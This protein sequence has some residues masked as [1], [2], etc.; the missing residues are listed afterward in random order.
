MR[1]RAVPSP[2][3]M[4]DSAEGG[5]EAELADLRLPHHDV[6]RKLRNGELRRARG[7][8]RLVLRQRR[9]QHLDTIE[10]ELGDLQS[11]VQE[12]AGDDVEAEAACLQPGAVFVLERDAVDAHVERDRALDMADLGAEHRPEA[13]GE[14]VL[15][16]SGLQEPEPRRKQRDEDEN[17]DTEPTQHTHQKACPKLT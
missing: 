12:G 2:P 3:T 10:G 14:E 13:V 16:G 11:S 1:T 7:R 6:D 5:R 9:A 17:G 15:A 4:D 8:L